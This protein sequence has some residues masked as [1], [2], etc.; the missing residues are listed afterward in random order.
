MTAPPHTVARTIRCPSCG[1][2]APV[3]TLAQHVPCP[4]CR[5]TIAVPLELLHELSVY[6]NRVQIAQQDAQNDA[7]LAARWRTWTGHDASP[8]R[9]AV[10]VVALVLGPILIFGVGGMLLVNARILP[11]AAA[12]VLSV[13]GSFGGMIAYIV[14]Y[15]LKLRVASAN[16][17]TV[18]CAGITC[19][20]CGAANALAAGQALERCRYCGV[21]LVASGTM[22]RDVV[23]DAERVARRARLDRYRA[24]R[25]GMGY[26]ARFSSGNAVLI[27]PLS[28]LGMFSL[29][30]VAVTGDMLFGSTKFSPGVFLLWGLCFAGGAL[31]YLFFQYRRNRQAAWHDALEAVSRPLGGYAFRDMDAAIS[32]LNTYWAGPMDVAALIAGPYFHT[33]LGV[34]EGYPFLIW[35]DPKAASEHHEAR[36]QVMVAA[37]FAGPGGV[38]WPETQASAAQWRGLESLGVACILN[39]AGLV[40]AASEPLRKAMHAAPDASLFANL[41]WRAVRYAQAR[42]GR[43]GEA[44]P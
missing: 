15:F 8:G 11:N 5:H 4:F 39:E 3:T 14:W 44:L 30:A 28:F 43:P 6:G 19:P 31:T 34:L 29:A 41:V 33:A 25:S 32:W 13:G 38:S 2:A 17:T 23:A 9:Q 21:S 18:A 1:G 35:A 36:V 42:G 37:W 7:A 22:I 20:Q 16:S 24:E 27:A 26:Y 12:P 10:M 40:V